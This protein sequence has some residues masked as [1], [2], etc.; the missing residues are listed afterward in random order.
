MRLISILDCVKTSRPKTDG[1]SPETYLYH[2]QILNIMG[3]SV[4][5]PETWIS[6]S[7]S[8]SSRYLVIIKCPKKPRKNP[9]FEEWNC[10]DMIVYEDRRYADDTSDFQLVASRFSRSIFQPTPCSLSIP[11]SRLW[12]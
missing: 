2:L 8:P 5:N 9:V 7:I 1:V 12:P 10:V 6:N 4:P 11:V 3:Y